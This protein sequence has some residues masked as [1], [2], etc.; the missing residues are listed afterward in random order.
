MIS[1]WLQAVHISP[2]THAAVQASV[3]QG[4]VTIFPRISSIKKAAASISCDA[5]KVQMYLAF[6]VALSHSL[7]GHLSEQAADAVRLWQVRPPYPSGFCTRLGC[8]CVG[9]TTQSSHHRC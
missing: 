5:E 9:H 4:A 3:T 7:A 1:V 2:G 8:D 6:W